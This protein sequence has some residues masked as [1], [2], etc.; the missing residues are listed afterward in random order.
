MDRKWLR[1]FR[2]WSHVE[3]VEVDAAG[4]GQL[5]LL[6]QRRLRGLT[7]AQRWEHIK[8][9]TKEEQ[10]HRL[11]WER[12]GGTVLPS[13]RQRIESQISIVFLFLD[14]SMRINRAIDPENYAL[15]QR[16]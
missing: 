13:R 14:V 5:L 10:S 3:T 2:T 4:G 16:E 7:R 8:A 6:R 12:H 1:D 15:T 11:Q 9:S